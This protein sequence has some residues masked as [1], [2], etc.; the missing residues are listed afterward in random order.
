[1]RRTAALAVLVCAL[2]A[3][4]ADPT[5]EKLIEQL[6]ASE[7]RVREAATKDLEARGESALPAMR[8]AV[9]GAS[10]EARRRLLLV[11]QNVERALVLA[12]R[13]VTLAATDRPLREVVAEIAKQTGYTIQF[14]SGP[15][16]QRTTVVE[17]NTPFWP[18][19][20]RLCTGAG[21]TLQGNDGTLM[22]LYQT[23]TLVPF[24]C[25]QGPFRLT[26]NGF[27]YNRTIQFGT[28]P[29][30]GLPR[31]DRSESLAFQFNVQTEPKL[32]LMAVGQPRL[33][34]AFD[35][36]GR[37]MLAPGGYHEAGYFG[38]SGYRTYNYS[39]QV[40]LGWP[41]KDARSVRLLRGTLPVVLLSEQKPDVVV[42]ELLKVKDRTFT[43]PNVQLHIDS[44]T[45]ANN[46]TAYQIKLTAKN[47]SKTA[48][49]DY[50]W[51]NSVHQRIEVLDAKG[52]KLYS[53]GYNWENNT[54]TSVTATFL[55][56]T[57]NQPTLGPPVKLVF[58]HW[59]TMPHQLEFE[60]KDLPLP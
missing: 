38:H 10:A 43:G 55:Y 42:D 26:A 33:T 30:N 32:P 35:N 2:P 24:V 13:R 15:K 22:Q 16:E 36:L 14:V 7:Y 17:E 60:F 9:T 44:V 48:A 39:S 4:A 1:M 49:Q 18:L 54:P 45:E 56:G 8:R 27:Y 40:A 50:S 3:F 6:D 5:V 34:A 59:V 29:R 31:Y 41:D 37:S 51:A 52:N 53:Q 46:K 57:N 47:T 58:N 20:D 11:I 19:M 28:L 12:P 23:D 25:Y 21:L